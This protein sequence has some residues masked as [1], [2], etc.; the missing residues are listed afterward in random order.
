[1]KPISTAAELKAAIAELEQK[2]VAQQANL[3]SEF[4]HTKEVLNP[5]HMVKNTFSKL[6]EMPEVKKTLISTIVGIGIGYLSNKAVHALQEDKLDRMLNNF[7]DN[8]LDRVVERNPQGLLSK[9][10]S[11]TRQIAKD[12]K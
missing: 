2:K 11:L 6:A 3:K 8:G 12:S 5:V 1:M 10:I 4:A 7:V 9:A